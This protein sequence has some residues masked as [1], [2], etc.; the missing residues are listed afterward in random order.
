MNIE[1]K[2]EPFNKIEE[3]WKFIKAGNHHC[4]IFV[5]DDIFQNRGWTHLKIALESHSIIC[6]FN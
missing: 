4:I 2:E 5:N 6:F 3:I 1:T